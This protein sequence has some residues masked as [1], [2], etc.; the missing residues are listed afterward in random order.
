V[1][2]SS[3]PP[4]QQAQQG[5]GGSQ[6]VFLPL[7]FGRDRRKPGI[8]TGFKKGDDLLDF[9]LLEPGFLE[10]VLDVSESFIS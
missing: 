8:V 5:P 4:F 10:K 9:S 7:F 3:K 6:V 1:P 2:V